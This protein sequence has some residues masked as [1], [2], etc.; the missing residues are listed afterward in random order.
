MTEQILNILIVDDEPTYRIVLSQTLKGCGH[1]IE[2]CGT[3]DAAIDLLK[4]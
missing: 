1:T 2:A 4:K 3:G